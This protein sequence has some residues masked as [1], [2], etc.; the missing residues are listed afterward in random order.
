MGPILSY[1]VFDAEQDGTGLCRALVFIMHE[2]AFLC[3]KMHDFKMPFSP[4]ICKETLSCLVCA[5]S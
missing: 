1:V 3:M 4:S 5:E 2:N